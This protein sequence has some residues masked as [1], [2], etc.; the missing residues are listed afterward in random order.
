[1]FEAPAPSQQS[2][3]LLAV[4]NVAWM[5]P[6]TSSFDAG[7]LVPIPKLP[8]VT[9]NQ[10]LF[11]ET[12]LK[13]ISAEVVAVSPRASAWFPGSRYG[14]NSPHQP[15]GP[16]QS[17]YSHNSEVPFGPT[18]PVAPVL[19]EGPAVPVDPVAPLGPALPDDPV[20]PVD[21]VGP[22]VPVDPVDPVDPDGPAVPVD[23]VEPVGPISPVVPVDPVGP[24]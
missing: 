8:F 24:V 3:S 10:E 2:R 18:G 15:L 6:L 19:P 1:M 12:G 7:E 21:P 20:V 5:A 22:C 14:N 4:A 11:P 16:V 23:P 9:L 17:L 13:Y